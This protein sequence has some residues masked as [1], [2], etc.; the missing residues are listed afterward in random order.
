VRACEICSADS[1]SSHS[2]ILVRRC[3]VERVCSSVWR[4]RD[5][6]AAKA[7]LDVSSASWVRSRACCFVRYA[8]S[9][10]MCA[11]W[12]LRFCV[13]VVCWISAC[14]SVSGC[15]DV[16][17]ATAVAASACRASSPSGVRCALSVSRIRAS[18]GFVSTYPVYKPWVLPSRSAQ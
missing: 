5:A 17:S 15:A 3:L 16:L 12:L 1:L 10:S 18:S 9:V 7:G 8:C 2:R 14:A 6:G 4:W 13:V 11:S